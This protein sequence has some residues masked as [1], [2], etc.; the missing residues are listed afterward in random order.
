VNTPDRPS[1]F[2]LTT[3]V[4]W[5]DY[6]YTE[7]TR[8][9]IMLTGMTDKE[10]N[11]LVPLAKSWLQAPKMRITSDTYKGGTYD[12]S[13]RAYLIEKTDQDNLTPCS[14]VVE[15]S[16]ESPLLNP[17]III[18]NWGNQLSTLSIDGQNIMHGKD[19][20]QGIRKGSDGEDLIIWIR[21]DSQKPV[22]ITLGRVKGR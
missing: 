4:Q 20:R 21:L 13:E 7:N 6:E 5:E 9:R 12:Q 22:E 11:E 10:A 15:A 1:H 2:N 8:T 14:F 19:F 16:R 3:F 18:K 17:A